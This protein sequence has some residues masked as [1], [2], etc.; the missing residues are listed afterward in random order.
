[1]CRKNKSLSTLVEECIAE[2]PCS[3]EIN[4]KISDPKAAIA[5]AEEKYVKDAVSVE[6]VDGLSIAYDDWRFNLRM[7]NTEPVVR[8]NVETKGDIGLMEEK[9][10]E[11]LALLD[12]VN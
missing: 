7:S 3:G 6:H 10:D 4:R 11:L 1:V 9:R 5:L 2:F 12:S 8:L